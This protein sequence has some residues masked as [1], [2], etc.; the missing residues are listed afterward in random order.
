MMASVLESAA[1]VAALEARGFAVEA[2]ADPPI[3]DALAA[4]AAPNV[5]T[6]VGRRDH[7]APCT[8]WIDAGGTVRYQRVRLVSEGP[9]TRV[10]RG[11]RR[12]RVTQETQQTVNAWGRVATA[13][14]V[15]AVLDALEEL[16]VSVTQK[17]T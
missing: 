2:Q 15:A 14:D 12:Y 16:T 5:I 13:Q 1:V 17:G 3:A 9:T 8:V 10:T 11:G 4:R 7:G 6:L